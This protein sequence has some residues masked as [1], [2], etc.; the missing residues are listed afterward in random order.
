[1]ESTS[2]CGAFRIKT[3][4]QSLQTQLESNITKGVHFLL[5]VQQS[6][7]TEIEFIYPNNTEDLDMIQLC[8]TPN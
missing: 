1:M 8:A 6:N 2:H 7:S 4:I 5:P 3:E